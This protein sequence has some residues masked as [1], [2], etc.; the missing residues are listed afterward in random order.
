MSNIQYFDIHT[1]CAGY[2][3]RLRL[4]TPEQ[5][6]PYWSV[7]VSALRGRPNRDGKYRKVSFDCNV[8][9]ELA[10]LRLQE[11]KPFLDQE[12]PVFVNVKIGDLEPVS[13][14]ARN[15]ETRHCIKGR[16]LQISSAKIEGTSFDFVAQPDQQPSNLVSMNPDSEMNQDHHKE[17]ERAS[18]PVQHVA[19]KATTPAKD[20]LPETIKLDKNDPNFAWKK[21]SL[22]QK[23]YRWDNEGKVWRKAA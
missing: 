16:L 2:L 18:E 22:K 19:D 10:S 15:G 12:Q 13:Y 23:G 11:L 4:V 8:V 1:R 14:R 6:N 21:D 3:N 9:G 5:G 17:Q 7:T 20:T